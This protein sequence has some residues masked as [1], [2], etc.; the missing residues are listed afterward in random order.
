MRSTKNIILITAALLSTSPLTA[1]TVLTGTARDASGKVLGNVVVKGLNRHKK[2][3]RYALTNKQGVFRLVTAA[4]DSI[5]TVTLSRLG[6]TTKTFLHKDFGKLKNVT[7]QEEAV[8][9]KEVVVKSVPI[10]QR[11]DTL[12]YSVNAFKKASDRTIEDV[13][14]RLPGINVD[15]AG[16]IYYQ[17]ERISKFYIENMD[18]LSGNY[19][20]AT[21]NIKPDDVAAVN[22]YENH[23]P[24]RAL[25][26]V[27]YSDKA[28][29]NLKIKENRKLKPIGY[30]Q[31]ALGYD[32]QTLW[33]SDVFG[34]VINK[35]S[36]Q[37]LSLKANNTGQTYNTA[38]VFGEDRITDFSSFTWDGISLS[39]QD[40]PNVALQRYVDNKSGEGTLN[41]LFKLKEKQTLTLNL[42]YAGDAIHYDNQKNS[43]IFDG[44]NQYQDFTEKTHAAVYS[45]KLTGKVKLENNTEKLYFLDNLTFKANFYHKR[46]ELKDNFDG[47]QRQKSNNCQLINQFNTI[48][49]VGKQVFQL[50]SNI[51]FSNTPV[52]RLEV[53]PLGA[54]QQMYQTLNETVFQTDEHTSFGWQ[55]GRVCSMGVRVNFESYYNN[56]SLYRMRTAAT[57]AD[58]AYR[59]YMLNTSLEPYFMC[60]WN[61]ITWQV[62]APLSLLN[63]HFENKAQK[64]DYRQDKTYGNVNTSI[65]WNLPK[66][67]KL[68]IAG[69]TRCNFGDISNYVTS[70][71]Y[72]TYKDVTTK[73]T[74]YL[75]NRNSLFANA[76]I[77][78]HNTMEGLFASLMGSISR[79]HTNSMR[80]TSVEDGNVYSNVTDRKNT[81]T[82]KMLTLNASKSIYCTGTS[83]Q[84]MASIGNS[85]TG[86]M[87]RNIVLNLENDRCMFNSRI[88]QELW[89]EKLNLAADYT[90]SQTQNRIDDMSTKMK[91]H[92]L[93]FS[94][95][96]FILKSLELFGDVTA[97][98]LREEEYSEQE[99]YANAGLR[100]KKSRIEV[101]LLAQNITNQRYYVVNKQVRESNY[102]Y[103]YHLR[104]IGLSLSVKYNF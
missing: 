44:E 95:S 26:N 90:Y 23:Q 103:V 77:N 93:S 84:V 19:T 34:M 62:N 20:L 70:P 3:K 37:L 67:L 28:A 35:K 12:T 10:R 83:V 78:F 30:L 43:S 21:K 56:I 54:E 61:R 73:G 22:V 104:P 79:S 13:I 63:I 60:K 24:V 59:G 4:E 98:W 5:T 99:N 68:H 38:Q 15:N 64:D 48:Y 46:F 8:N 94:L 100:Y 7:M 96:C 91:E 25:K 102:R 71:I 65:D 16:G 49:H 33:K 32:D 50:Q 47:L 41:S 36:Q 18:M 51:K 6:Y 89:A 88:E 92:A 76:H 86:I 14:K 75:T 42:R 97:N 80:E 58:D 81:F 101:E 72:Y 45:N 87:S 40:I 31:Q 17:G 11:G 82:D 9:I 55:L 29:L 27:A 52:N 39:A 66:G 69:G 85:K 74:G 2:L 1:Q 57:D 53:V